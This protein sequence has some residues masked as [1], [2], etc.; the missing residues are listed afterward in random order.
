[1]IFIIKFR[2]FNIFKDD[3]GNCVAEPGCTGAQCDSLYCLYFVLTQQPVLEENEI[4]FSDKIGAGSTVEFWIDFEGLS[5]VDGLWSNVIFIGADFRNRAGVWV[6]DN[7]EFAIQWFQDEGND[8]ETGNP[9]WHN[10]QLNFDM[11]ELFGASL[12]V[13]TSYHLKMI[14]SEYE[15]TASVNHA[16]KRTFL[17]FS[18]REST[19][20]AIYASRSGGLEL[21]DPDVNF[22]LGDTSLWTDVEPQMKLTHIRI[23]DNECG[24]RGCLCDVVVDCNI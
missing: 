4:G 1:M 15:M 17:G 6:R 5:P 10:A 22:P 12:Q 23:Y 20:V 16:E 21:G 2:F 14:I 3:S 8:A 24:E 13:G 9:V 11:T 7:N 18:A 19:S